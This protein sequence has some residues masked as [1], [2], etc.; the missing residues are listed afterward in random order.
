MLALPSLGGTFAIS[1]FNLA[2][3]YFVSRLGTEPLAAMGFT[4]PIVMLVGS[5]SH[6]L[7]MGATAVISQCIGEGDHAQARRITT[8]TFF[9]A[10]IVVSTL[11]AIGLLS[12]DF[13]FT[14]LGAS[15]DV[16]A[17]VKQFMTIWYLGV[18][19]MIIPMF[20]EGI[21]RATGDTVSSSAI[22]VAGASLNVVLDPLLIF[23]IGVFPAM[24][25][26]GAA[27]A[28]ILTR[29]FTLAAGVFILHHRHRLI[30]WAL[31]TPAAM[32][33]SWRR[34]LHIGIPSSATALLVPISSAVITRIVA[35]FGP[36]AVAACGAGGRLEMFAFMIPMSLG[37]SLVPF[38]GQNWGAGRRDRVELCRKYSNR[39]ALYWGVCCALAFMLASRWMAGLFTEDPAVLNI[40]SMYL[41][42]IPMGYGMREVH[43]FVG[44]SFNAVGR[45]MDSAA[46]N[47]V[48]VLFLLI[49]LAYLGSRL[50]GIEG[51]FWGSVAADVFAAI[52]AVAWSQRVF[53]PRRAAPSSSSLHAPDAG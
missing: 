29:A 33:A 19:F 13:V 39:F 7:G 23:G 25:I 45:P 32:W 34:V 40:L 12:M 41:C 49:P 37:M 51:V 6:G 14:R 27:I 48:R 42:I 26:R 24:G 53:A 9:L 46:I 3:T 52:A 47:V 22:M 2:D 38:I 20:A 35:G 4:F 50:L 31:P 10:L 18:I 5:I 15:G 43:R 30:E 8:H 16:L 44:F 28:T 11:S 17:L 36:E 21:I 1:A